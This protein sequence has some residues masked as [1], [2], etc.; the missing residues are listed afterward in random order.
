MVYKG[1]VASTEAHGVIPCCEVLDTLGIDSTSEDGGR[2]WAISFVFGRQP[3]LGW[4]RGI[5]AYT[6]NIV[7]GDIPST[8]ILKPV[9]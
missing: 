2:C 5:S 4:E 1:L 9:L 3:G 8:E 7:Q 6:I